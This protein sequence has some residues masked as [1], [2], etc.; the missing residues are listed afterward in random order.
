MPKYSV[1]GLCKHLCSGI[2]ECHKQFKARRQVQ[3]MRNL[4]ARNGTCYRGS[5]VYEEALE[6]ATHDPLESNR[7]EKYGRCRVLGDTKYDSI[8][9][10]EEG[11]RR[12][13]GRLK[14]SQRVGEALR[15]QRQCDSYRSGPEQKFKFRKPPS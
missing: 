3:I 13:N 14:G 10:L 6:E 12:C 4:D 8:G 11:R 9:W 7:I 5:K 1:E 2:G 15:I